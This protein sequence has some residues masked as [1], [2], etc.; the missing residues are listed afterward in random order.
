MTNRPLL[1]FEERLAGCLVGTAVADSLGLPY[2]GLSRSRAAK[3]LG[4]AN[5]HRFVFGRGMVSDDTEHICMVAQALIFANGDVAKFQTNFAKRLKYWFATL[6]AGVGLATAKSCLKLWLF[7]S[8]TTSG[9]FSAGN[10]PAM[11]AA[12]FGAYFKDIQQL[13][14][15]LKAATVVTHTDPKA[16][17]GA[18]AVALATRLGCQHFHVDGKLFLDLYSATVIDADDELLPKLQQVIDSVQR[19]DTVLEFA[20]QL[21]CHQNAS[22]YVLQTVPMAIHAWLSH[23]RDYR[24]AVTSI[25]ACGGDADTTA[26]IVGGIV[27]ATVGENQIPVQWRDH[28]IEWPRTL[29]WISRLSQQLATASE[30]Q[31]AKKKPPRL[32]VCAVFI[33]NVIFLLIVLGHGFRRLLPL[34]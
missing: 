2:E 27:G 5:R 32:S 24:S 23:Q 1:T 10:G 33:R 25:I 21:G 13:Q 16:Y 26:A 31:Q 28:V 22:G 7:C 34:Y 4:P 30:D 12:I 20:A 3:I 14:N 6:P 18:I 11:R 15:F 19:G 17:H 29:S 8:P 9:I